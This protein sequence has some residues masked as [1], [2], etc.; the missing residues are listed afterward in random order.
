MRDSHKASRASANAEKIGTPDDRTPHLKRA[1]G[2]CARSS[3]VTAG[4]GSMVSRRK[5]KLDDGATR[6]FLGLPV[7]GRRGRAGVA[8]RVRNDPGTPRKSVAA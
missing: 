1:N 6:G 5:V 2:G 8:S 3:S 4:R 7:R